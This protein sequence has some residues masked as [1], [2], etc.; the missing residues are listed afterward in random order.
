MLLMSIGYHMIGEAISVF[1]DDIT[2]F[3]TSALTSLFRSRFI[4]TILV[5]IK[6]DQK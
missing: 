5:V 2:H 3:D 4:C 6:Q 1:W